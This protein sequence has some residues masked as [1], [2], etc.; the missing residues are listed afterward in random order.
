MKRLIPVVILIAAAIFVSNKSYSDD[1]LV[2]AIHKVE[3]NGRVGKIL[4]DNG[5]ALGPLQIHYS[6]WKDAVTFDK[7][8]GGSYADCKDLDYSIKIFTAYTKKYAN[9]KSAEDKARIW[10]GG[11]TGNKKTVTE[12][13]WKKVKANL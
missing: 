8:I 9:G 13:Y 3:T 5:R 7:S 2:S 1:K 10:N 11:P 12:H 6:N 4:G